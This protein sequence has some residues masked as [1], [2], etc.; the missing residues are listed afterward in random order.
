MWWPGTH[1]AGHLLQGR[2][3][4]GLNGD[5][6]PL[7]DPNLLQLWDRP[8]ELAVGPRGTVF[9]RDLRTCPPPAQPLAELPLEVH[10]SPGG[11]GRRASRNA[12]SHAGAPPE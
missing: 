4:S 8:A 2:T 3:P 1:Q 9:I 7:L 12:E 6:D 10:P 5:H 11:P